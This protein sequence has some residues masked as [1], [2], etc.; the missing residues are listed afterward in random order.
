MSI[1]FCLLLIVLFLANLYDRTKSKVWVVSAFVFMVLLAGL[2]DVNVGTDSWNYYFQFMEKETQEL[3]LSEYIK[4]E[5]GFKILLRIAQVLGSNYCSLFLLVGAVVYGSTL[6]GMKRHTESMTI[7]LFVY[8]TLGLYAFCFNGER[9]ALAIGIYMNAIQYVKDRDFKRYCIVVLLAALFHRTIIVA[10]PLYFLFTRTYNITTI[11]FVIISS[12]VLTAALPYL[13]TFASTIDSKYAGYFAKNEV[14][15]GASLMFAYDVMTLFFI[16]MRRYIERV[17]R[18]FYDV[19][20]LMFIVGSTI[21]TLVI[22]TGIYVEVSRFASYFH[23]S[24]VFLWPMILHC[25]TYK[26]MSMVKFAFLIGHLSFMYVYYGKM[27]ALSPY[28]FN[29]DIFSK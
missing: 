21:F 29:T 5:G 7:S 28:I 4:D 17:K 15:A 25:K 22:A 6:Q 20:L 12:F 23:V 3:S 8:I 14:N 27:A 2:R 9:Q 26:Q 18:R 10:I 19:C 24:A 16:Y 11:I 1:Y 13:L